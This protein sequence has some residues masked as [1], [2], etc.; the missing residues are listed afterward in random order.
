[1]RK[2]LA[3]LT[4]LVLPATL[5]AQG[6]RGERGGR[7]FGPGRMGNP[8]QIVLQHGSELNL[9][10]DQVTKLEAVA[11]KLEESNK[12]LVADL[13]KQ[14]TE[15]QRPQA[16]TEQQREQMR[17]VMEKLRANREDAQKQVAAILTQQQNEQLRSF[18]PERIKGSERPG[19]RGGRGAF[20]TA[21]QRN[22]VQSILEH[23]SEL[24]L[25]ADQVSKLESISRTLEQKNQPILAKLQQG[26][27]AGVR[28]QELTEAQRTEM[29][30]AMETLRENTKASVEQARSVLS[31]EQQQKLKAIRPDRRE[32]RG[33]KGLG[34]RPR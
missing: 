23:R 29:R 20:G 26:H 6:G 25:S 21:A 32:H 2:F 30:T 10:A 1:M 19:G 28:P 34:Q 11:S 8:V 13:Q 27:Q 24:S 3:A 17:G 18:R 9:T 15:G 16:M 31:K 4:L 7:G 22:P 12:P 33:A 14:R 5:L